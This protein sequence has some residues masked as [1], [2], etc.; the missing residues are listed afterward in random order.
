MISCSLHFDINEV[1]VIFGLATFD[2]RGQLRYG[3]VRPDPSHGSDVSISV[4]P[5]RLKFS[6]LT[7]HGPKTTFKYRKY[8]LCGFTY[9]IASKCPTATKADKTA[10][11]KM[12]ASKAEKVTK[13]EKSTKRVRFGTQLLRDTALI[14]WNI[15]QS[16]LSPEVLAQ[17]SWAEFK[18][19]LLEEF[20][21]KRTM[22]RIEKEFRSLVKGSLT[23]REYTRQFMEKLG[24]VG[25]AA[26][27]EKDKMKAYLNGLPADMQSMVHNSKASNLR[28]MVEE[29]QYM[30]E[31]FA[32]SKS[33]GAVV[34]SDKRKW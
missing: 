3:Y 22:D 15:I 26:P 17:L 25:H 5:A 33:E 19:K 24:L 1:L 34:V 32:K 12:N 31:M 30:E 18:K 4:G 14:W 9:H 16:T 10:K 6:N 28:E 8:Y 21:N 20:C 23:V 27:T 13:A 7:T 2:P 11:V 29:S